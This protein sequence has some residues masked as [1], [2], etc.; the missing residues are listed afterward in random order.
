MTADKN[1]L[2]KTALARFKL[3]VEATQK[4]RQ[5]EIEDLKFQVPELQWADEVRNQRAGQIIDGVPVPARPMLSIPKIDQP[6]QLITNQEK[7]AHL[8]VQISAID[9]EATDDTAE[10][11]QDIYRGIE[12]DSR[13]QLAR[14]WAFDRAVKCGFGVYRILTEYDEQSDNPTDQKIVIKRILNQNSVY[15][16]PFAQEPDWS[17]GQW[18]LIVTDLPWDRYVAEFGTV[19]DEGKQSKLVGMSESELVALGNEQKGWVNGE[20]ESRVVRVAEYFYLEYAKQARGERMVNEPTVCWCKLNAVE[21][22]EET[23]LPGRWIPII[24]VIGKELQTFDEE[25]RFTGVIGPA[26]GAQMLFNYEVSGAAEAS[27]LAPMV[28][29]VGAEGVF[30]GHEAK[31]GQANMRRFPYL[32]Y[33]PKTL[34]G[35]EVGRPERNS[36]SADITSHLALIQVA[37]DAIQAA[38]F[39][40]DPSL[41]KMTDKD[42]SGKAIQALQQQSDIGNSNYIQNLKDISV[43]HEARIILS[44]IPH[45]YDR[46]GRLVR[47]VAANDDEQPVMIN[48]P[49]VMDPERKRPMPMQ[50]GQMPPTGPNGQP[51]EVKHYDLKKGIYGVAVTVGKSYATGR[52]EGA[53]AL[54]NLFGNIPQTFPVL[55]DIWAQFQDWPGHDEAAE[56]LKK[57]LPPN[58]QKDDSGQP[59]VEQLQQELQKGAQAFQALQQQ[60][61]M[62]VDQ[63]KTDQAKQQANIAIAKEKEA[64]AQ[65]IEQMKISAEL[66]IARIKAQ[67]EIAK[68]QIKAQMAG[69]RAQFDAEIANEQQAAEQAHESVENAR[70][71]EHEKDLSAVDMLNAARDRMH[72][73][74]EADR[75][76]QHEA[77]MA[78][79]GHAQT[80]EQQQQ[81]AD[82]APEPREGAE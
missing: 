61:M 80:L 64:S 78:E 24:P 23:T 52:K 79:M 30:E 38:T 32:E 56:R 53:D 31:W 8:G 82:L 81:A 50:P 33:R 4:Q 57:S 35:T 76:R 27:A 77:G 34:N 46:P 65:A 55:G 18:A 17:D 7:A 45:Y 63:I 43:Q 3:A 11:L 36:P 26:K 1:S 58:L 66:E 12:R 25:R 74:D 41:G 29:W 10:M 70:S 54:G 49:H 75:G 2:V 48:Q 72:E 44:W 69:A 5:R 67:A 42:R 40:P 39:T 14:S 51:L 16:D 6:I 9:L 19:G 71:R 60:L 22:L 37:D 47:S 21:V 59:T 15:L 28:P 62:A 68:E 13:A 20:K 73:A